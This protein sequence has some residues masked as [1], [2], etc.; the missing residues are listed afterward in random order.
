VH[1][2]R[3]SAET[4]K[5]EFA[6]ASYLLAASNNLVESILSGYYGFFSIALFQQ[7]T[8][9]IQA[10]HPDTRNPNSLALLWIP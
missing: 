5:L 9:D 8:L 4:I 2:R 7:L 10:N 6:C 3:V 1:L